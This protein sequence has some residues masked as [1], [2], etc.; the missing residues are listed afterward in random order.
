MVHSNCITL[1]WWHSYVHRTVKSVTRHFK[2]V[3]LMTVVLLYPVDMRL[4]T[5]WQRYIWQTTVVLYV[6]QNECKTW[7]CIPEINISCYFYP[8][9]LIWLQQYVCI[10]HPSKNRSAT[11]CCLVY[12]TFVLS[13]CTSLST[14]AERGTVEQS[15]LCTPKTVTT[16]LSN[17]FHLMQYNANTLILSREALN[18]SLP[19]IICFS[20]IT[21]FFLKI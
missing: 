20:P 7:Y 4:L 13:I 1:W 18:C 9:H 14:V 2:L 6:I 15:F 19:Q 11:G 21:F 16:Q 10:V 5:S 3:N 8:V 12:I 17:I